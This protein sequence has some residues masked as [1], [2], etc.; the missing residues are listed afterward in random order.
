VARGANHNFFN[1]IWADELGFF[2]PEPPSGEPLPADP[3]GSDQI[4][5]T[6]L[7]REDQEAFASAAIVPFMRAFVAGAP[8]ARSLLA[9]LGFDAPPPREIAG[10]AVN[11]SY[12]AP[13]ALRLD[14]IRPAPGVGLRRN[15]LG[16]RQRALQVDGFNLCTHDPPAFF[17]NDD[18][19]IRGCG[20]SPAM[21]AH[22]LT[23]LR[24]AWSSERAR[25]VSEIPSR[26]ADLRGFAALSL[27]A[28]LDPADRQRNP[29]GAARPF[30]VALR[31]VAGRTAVFA[32]PRSHPAVHYPVRGL[33][34]LGTIRIPLGVFRGVDVSRVAAVELRFD[35]SPRG[36]LLVTDLSFVR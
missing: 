6:R 21:Q 29:P 11:V 7:S 24:I 34:V 30:S 14:V 10:A 12:Q 16:G 19:E 20:S 15:R 22:A 31:D 26:F 2:L 25:V 18:G 32:V 23:E 9:P 36:R 33:A 3:C 5:K 13:S 4:G 1:R 35:R 8:A 27:R 28:V 17:G